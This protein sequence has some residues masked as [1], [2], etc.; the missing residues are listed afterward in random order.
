[1]TRPEPPITIMDLAMVNHGVAIVVAAWRRAGWDTGDLVPVRLERLGAIA[2]RASRT[3]RRYVSDAADAGLVELEGAT[4]V[5]GTY[6]RLGRLNLTPEALEAGWTFLRDARRCRACRHLKIN[7]GNTCKRCRVSRRRDLGGVLAACAE[8]RKLQ[9]A[10][11]RVSPTLLAAK[12]KCPL[13]TSDSYDLGRLI[14]LQGLVRRLIRE[15]L[16][17][18]DQA[19]HWRARERA[20]LGGASYE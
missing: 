10:G 20:A 18:D 7:Q 2:G 14:P 16:L 1:M 12:H 6:A 11:K 8:A 13:W 15:G 4:G 19:T 17:T 5:G 3:M 9:R